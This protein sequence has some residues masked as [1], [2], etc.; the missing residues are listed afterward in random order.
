MVISIKLSNILDINLKDSSFKDKFDINL[1]L[2]LRTK[3]GMYIVF[4]EQLQE[5]EKTLINKFGNNA[6]YNLKSLI[7]KDSTKF[8]FEIEGIDVNQMPMDFNKIEI[9]TNRLMN[10]NG[11]SHFDNYSAYMKNKILNDADDKFELNKECLF[12]YHHRVFHK[13]NDDQSKKMWPGFSKVVENMISTTYNG[14]RVDKH[15]IEP[16][17]VNLYLDKLFAFISKSKLDTF[18]KYGIIHY[19]LVSIHPFMDG[20]GR[21]TRLFTTK[22]VENQEHVFIPIDQAIMNNVKEYKHALNEAQIKADVEP[23]LNYFLK[24]FNEQL[25]INIALI[26]KF[27]NERRNLVNKLLSLDIPLKYTSSLSNFLLTKKTFTIKSLESKLDRRTTTSIMQVLL[28]SKII[29]ELKFDTNNKEKVYLSNYEL[30]Q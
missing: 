11:R 6:Y 7:S 18:I 13:D 25:D 20:N 29:K 10:S 19:Y 14:E 28:D 26:K 23:I 3:L 16:E 2:N 9:T 4:T 21:M 27:H 5:S 24:C 15:F 8:N 12:N 1:L 22:Y 17:L 30:K